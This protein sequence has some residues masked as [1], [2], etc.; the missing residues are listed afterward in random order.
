[1]RKFT[2]VTFMFVAF[3]SLKYS[4]DYLFIQNY[5]IIHPITTPKTIYCLNQLHSLTP[6]Y[7]GINY[8][9]RID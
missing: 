5:V 4:L 2:K 7:L 6:R 9:I 1:M 8:S 3:F